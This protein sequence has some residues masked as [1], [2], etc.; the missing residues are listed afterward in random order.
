VVLL[1]RQENGGKAISDTQNKLLQGQRTQREVLQE[2]HRKQND[3]QTSLARGRLT[4]GAA[5]FSGLSHDF[6][7]GE[8]F[9]WSSNQT[10]GCGTLDGVGEV[11]CLPLAVGIATNL[12]LDI[13]KDVQSAAYVRRLFG[14]LLDQGSY[15]A[16]LETTN[17]TTTLAEW[18]KLN[19]SENM[20]SGLR[21]AFGISKSIAW[22]HK[23]ELLV[24][25]LNDHNILVQNGEGSEVRPLL[26]DLENSRHVRWPRL[27][28][29]MLTDLVVPTKNCKRFLRR[30]L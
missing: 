3:L 24:K 20:L 8:Q 1:K 7:P 26:T 6:I 19:T 2:L 27:S 23:A 30:S 28:S 11:Q 25:T 4:F 15:F 13:Y 10:S 16:I 17:N 21:L 14:V 5:N 29:K 9:Q 22:L 18:C 12:Y